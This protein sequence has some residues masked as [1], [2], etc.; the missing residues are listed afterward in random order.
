MQTSFTLAQLADPEIA[1][2]DRI[3]RSCVHCGFCVATCPTYVLLGDELDSPR[4]RIYLVKGMLE[5]ETPPTPGTVKHIDRCL[6]CL[7]CM[8]TCPSG[9]DYMHLVDQARARIARTVRR[10]LGER[11]RRWLLPGLISRPALFRLALIPASW[12]RGFFRRMPGLVGRMATLAPT[13]IPK[14]ARTDRPGIFPAEGTRRARIALLPGCAQKVLAPEINAAAVR[15]LTRLGIEVVVGPG[16]GCCGALDHHAGRTAASRRLAVRN[17]AVW[18]REFEGEGLDAI[19]TT[20]SGCGVVVRDYD[21]MLAGDDN[22]AAAGARVATAA[23]DIAAFLSSYEA[24]IAALRKDEVPPLRVAYHA[25][26]SLQHGQKV[27]QAPKDLLSEVGFTL[28]EIAEAHLCCG[29]AGTYN[30]LQPEIAAQLGARKTT[31]LDATESAV[32]ATGNI[33][34]MTQIAA[35]TKTPVVHTIELLDWATGGPPPPAL[36]EIAS[37]G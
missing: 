15:L 21:H 25:A 32:I 11:L 30:I 18:W 12:L 28:P 19:I 8:T 35:G 16:T 2:A 33:G 10:P 1:E 20:A 9:V 26:C 37:G 3:L 36:T 34:C 14:P 22:F 4:G 5:A 31:H 24:D 6:S 23:I 7:S 27:T 29:S 13:S 17:A